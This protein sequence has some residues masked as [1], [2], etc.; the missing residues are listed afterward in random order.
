MITCFTNM[1]VLKM[2]PPFTV[3]GD[4]LHGCHWPLDSGPAVCPSN[5]LETLNEKCLAVDASIWIYRL[6]KAV[7]DKKDAALYNSY[8]VDFFHRLCNL[9]FFGIKPVLCLMA[10][11]RR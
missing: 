9:L 4:L 11:P 6:L 1:H 7:R 8:V 5:N 10:G 3:L 2:V